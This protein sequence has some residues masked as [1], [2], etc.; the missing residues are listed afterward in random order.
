TVQQIS[1]SWGTTPVL[2]SDKGSNDE[3]VA[4]AL[5][6]ACD[7]GQ[8]RSGELVAVLAGADNRSRSANV[9]RLERVP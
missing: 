8:V 5:K 1:L 9:L 3:M 7:T 2:V 6:V 4:Q